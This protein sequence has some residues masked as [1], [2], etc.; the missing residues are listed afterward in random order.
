MRV[1]LCTMLA[2]FSLNFLA[3][4]GDENEKKYCVVDC[5]FIGVKMDLFLSLF[6]GRAAKTQFYAAN[7]HVQSNGV[8]SK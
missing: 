7:P 5:R 6:C 3:N 2:E 4:F 8:I 1:S